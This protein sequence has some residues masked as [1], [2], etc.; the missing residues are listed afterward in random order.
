MAASRRD[1]DRYHQ[2]GAVG[3][4]GHSPGHSPRMPN[5]ADRF[6]SVE[7]AVSAFMG[8]ESLDESVVLWRGCPVGVHVFKRERVGGDA[9]GEIFVAVCVAG[10][11][12]PVCWCALPATEVRVARVNAIYI[13]LQLYQQS[14]H[15]K[16]CIHVLFV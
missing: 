2:R 13:P 8:G 4:V 1:G 7:I 15:Y 16:V 3:G 10:D 6:H 9:V 12:H 5:P 11:C 14:K